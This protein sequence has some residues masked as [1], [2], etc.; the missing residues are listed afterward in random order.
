MEHFKIAKCTIA[1]CK[2][3]RRGNKCAKDGFSIARTIHLVSNI[4]SADV[5]QVRYQINIYRLNNL[6]EN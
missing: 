3:W 1:A 5:C 6:L 2:N 4:H